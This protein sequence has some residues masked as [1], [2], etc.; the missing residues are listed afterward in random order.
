MERN[1]SSMAD[2]DI[3]ITIVPFFGKEE[4]NLLVKKRDIQQKR[5]IKIQKALFKVSSGN[6]LYFVQTYCRKAT[7][8]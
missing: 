6:V 8:E 2:R 7:E 5:V 1:T 3:G 4:I